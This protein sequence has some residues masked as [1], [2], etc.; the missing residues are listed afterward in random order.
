MLEVALKSETGFSE[1]NSSQTL[2]QRLAGIRDR[3]EDLQ[4]ARLEQPAVPL[5]TE[6]DPASPLMAATRLVR[7]RRQRELLFGSRFF[8]DPV[9]DILLDLYIAAL[10]GKQ[11]TISSL[12]V[13]AT[14][15][16]TTALRWIGTM[17]REGLCRR[18]PDPDDKRRAYVEITDDAAQVMTNLLSNWLAGK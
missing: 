14:V 16:A 12:C 6:P 4:S 5:R 18:R 3:Q 11:V 2:E 17:E 8:A 9:W 10:R 15:P 13:A 7:L 1:D